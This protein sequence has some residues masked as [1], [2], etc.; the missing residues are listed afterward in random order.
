MVTRLVPTVTLALSGFLLAACD[1]P[2]IPAKGKSTVKPTKEYDALLAQKF[3]YI[4]CEPD[5][6]QMIFVVDCTKKSPHRNFRFEFPMRRERMYG[7]DGSV[8]ACPTGSAQLI[9]KIGC[10]S[11]RTVRRDGSLSDAKGDHGSYSAICGVSLP[12]DTEI[13]VRVS[14]YWPSAGA[15]RGKF[16]KE[17]RVAIGSNVEQQLSDEFAVKTYFKEPAAS[18]H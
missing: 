2:S 5:E 13:D 3:H 17:F 1:T 18:S 9:M 15:S 7:D 16:K 11:Q 4:P 14:F 6:A 8:L 10:G 12:C